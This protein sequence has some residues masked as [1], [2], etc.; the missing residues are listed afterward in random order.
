MTQNGFKLKL[1]TSYRPVTYT[2][3][4]NTNKLSGVTDAANDNTSML[5]DFKYDPATK[6]ATI[7]F[8]FNTIVRKDN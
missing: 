6:G 8:C 1:F 5:V 2:S 3:Q 7:N 4:T